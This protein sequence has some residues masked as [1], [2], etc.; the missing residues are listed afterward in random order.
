MDALN[1]QRNRD[2]N[3]KINKAHCQVPI[4]VTITIALGC[5]RSRFQG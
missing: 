5:A 1:H 4:I 3:E 2:G